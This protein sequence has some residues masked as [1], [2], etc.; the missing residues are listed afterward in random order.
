MGL[1]DQPERIMERRRRERESRV[2]RV[3]SRGREL[4]M[5]LVVVVAEGRRVVRR[6][7][8]WAE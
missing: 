1:K 7:C 5:M 3:I 8:S 2:S 6:R 4:L